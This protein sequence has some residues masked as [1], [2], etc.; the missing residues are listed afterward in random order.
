MK[1]VILQSNYIPWKGYFDLINDADIFIFYDCVQYTKNDWRNRNSIYTKNGKQWLTIP[2]PGKSVNGKIDE[3]IITDNKWQE[4]H[5]KS[6]YYGYKSSPYFHQLEELITDYLKDRKWSNLS[7]LNQYLIKKISRMLGVTTKFLNARNFDLPEGRVEKLISILTQLNATDYISGLAAKNYLEGSEH[8]FS[9]SGINLSYK[10]Y[11]NYPSYKQLC[12]P[13][14]N[15]VSVLD[16]IS[17]IEL[18]NISNFIFKN[19]NI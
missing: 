6:L 12:M 13:F 15:S 18:S 4:K 1:V 2:I 16:L 8:L 14:V 3:V 10:H 7:E 9:E 19:E 17:N 11:P 5:F